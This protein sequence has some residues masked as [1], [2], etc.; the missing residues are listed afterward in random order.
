LKEK[1]MKEVSG[2]AP[3]IAPNTSIKAQK[4]TDY[5][6]RI[7]VPNTD[8]ILNAIHNMSDTDRK[9]ILAALLELVGWQKK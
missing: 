4:Q 6:D 5:D 1:E 9:K 7:R 2:D 8:V 3:S